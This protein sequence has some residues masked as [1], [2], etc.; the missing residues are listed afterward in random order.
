MEIQNIANPDGHGYAL[1]VAFTLFCDQM[2]FQCEPERF[3]F[4]F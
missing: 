1:P 3:W 2:A 4:A